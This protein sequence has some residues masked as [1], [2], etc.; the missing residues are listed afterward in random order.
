[1]QLQVGSGKVAL[2]AGDRALICWGCSFSQ[3]QPASFIAGVAAEL[4][5]A[6]RKFASPEAKQR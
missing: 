6:S 5:L 3:Q 1:M 2:D 4:S